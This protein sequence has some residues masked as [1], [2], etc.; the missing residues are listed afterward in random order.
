MS[1]LRGLRILLRVTDFRH[2]LAVRLLSQAADGVYQVALATYVVF[3]PENQATPGAIASALAV[4]LL[5]YSVVGP[6]AGVLLDRWQRRQ[7]F[8]YGNLLRAL[9]AGCT[10]TLILASVPGWLFYVSALSVTAVNRFVLAGLSAA[11]PRVV[12]GDQLVIANSLSPTAGT[13]AATLGGGIAFGV[14]FVVSD[15]DTG[16]VLTGALLY[17]CAALTSLLMKRDLLGPDWAPG[18]PTLTDALASTARGL[19]AGLHHLGHRRTASRA[20]AAMTA[21]RFCYGALTVMVLML[22]R[23]AW[24]TDSND[25]LALLG[26]ALGVSGAGFFVAAVITPWAAARFG[27]YG[28]MTLC[29]ASAAVLLPVLGLSFSPGPVVAAAF[30]LGLVSQGAKIATDTTVQTSVDDAFRGRV[31]SLYDVLFNVAYVGAAAAAALILPSD[32]RSVTLL[33][34]VSLLYAAVA[35]AVGRHRDDVSRE[36]VALTP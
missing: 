10:A 2:L 4:L 15:S 24:T 5:P 9:L 32:G 33:V 7:I 21:M 28:W 16:V 29:A 8:L 6:F 19:T 3:S 25:G 11:L 20:L 31:F 22:C 13:L 35:F 12:D 26:V 18:R 27:P 30:L 36:T 14:R 34:S 1:V 17:L 23:Y